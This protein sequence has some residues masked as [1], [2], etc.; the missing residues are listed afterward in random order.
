MYKFFIS[1]LI[2]LTVATGV[3]A[4]KVTEIRGQTLD[5]ATGSPIVGVLVSATPVD[6]TNTLAYTVSG[7]DGSFVLKSNSGFPDRVKVTARSMVTKVQE[8]VISSAGGYV[9]FRLEEEIQ[10]LNEVHVQG[11]R[12][13]QKGDTLNYY[14]ESFRD[15][16]D[17]SIGDILKKLPGIQIASG[18]RIL[19]QNKEISKFYIEG[20]DLLQGRYGLVTNNLDAAK[21]AT[22]QVLENHQPI[23]VL[24][25]EELPETA[26]INIKL[27]KSAL[28][29]FFMTA[30]LG[31]GIPLWLLSNELVGMRF[32]SNQ[33][34]ML[35]Y[36]GDNTGRDIVQEMTSFYGTSGGTAVNLFS[37]ERPGTPSV[38][39]Q[40][41]LFNN[42]HIGSINDLHL[43]GKGYS[44][45]SNINYLYDEQHGEGI[46]ERHITVDG[47][48]RDVHIKEDVLDIQKKR[49]LN[50]TFVLEKN[51]PD[52][53]ENNRLDFYVK[54]N[55]E[56]STVRSLTPIVQSLTLPSFSVEDNYRRMWRN[57]TGRRL[58]LEGKIIYSSDNQSLQVDPI[59]FPELS[60]LSSSAR[61]DILYDRFE[62]EV[63]VAWS[64]SKNGWSLGLRTGGFYSFYELE[65]D[66]MAGTNTLPVDSLR[67]DLK[68]VG[69]GLMGMVSVGYHQGRISLSSNAPYRLQYLEVKNN[70]IERREGGL[71]PLIEPSLT[72]IWQATNRWSIVLSSFRNES[73][74]TIM[75]DMTGYLMRSYRNLSRGDGTIHKSSS[76]RATLSA[77]YRNPWNSLYLSASAQLIN[78]HR[79]YISEVFYDGILSAVNWTYHP[80]N[81]NTL[82]GT[83]RIEYTFEAINTEAKL[84]GSYGFGTSVALN[85]GVLSDVYSN[86]YTIVPSFTTTITRNLI[87][88]YSSTWRE[89]RNSVVGKAVFAPIRTLNQTFTLAAAPFDGMTVTATVNHY[90][91]GLLRPIPS[92]WFANLGL[93]YK[94]DKTEIRLDWTNV[95]GTTEYASFSYNDV[96][97]SYSSTRLRPSELL[98]RVNFSIF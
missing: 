16:T 57:K 68:R 34:N 27:R 81:S 35:V 73:Y 79:D 61:Q 46:T 10:Q 75:D 1:A 47:G 38:D 90:Y 37:P 42:A 94:K 71:Y 66:I 86:F 88:K 82:T 40:Y 54:K 4:Q 83:G 72:F 25:G 52:Y 87:I 76:T 91:N 69:A 19:Y 49:E 44:L 15:A 24:A 48:S 13:E 36:K 70:C 65:T 23:K 3:S 20:M 6:A 78:S 51:E 12:I 74:G 32:T 41:R 97:S 22:V 17:R 95:F 45:T 98:L 53:Y 63:Y 50:G 77:S 59:L 8:K 33:Q 29:A 31:F 92:Y 84:G 62:S 85:Q 56:E 5:G 55:G 18:G 26:A 2:L 30:Q 60:L 9:E 7:T 14:V 80:N 28:G 64:Y 11:S 39:A 21:V 93:R 96:T 58:T 67:N 89:G 43:L